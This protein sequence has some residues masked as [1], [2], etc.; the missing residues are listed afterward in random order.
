MKNVRQCGSNVTTSIATTNYIQQAP[1]K[2]DNLI[3]GIYELPNKIHI[4]YN[5][6]TTRIVGR[7]ERFFTSNNGV[8]PFKPQGSER[9]LRCIT[10]TFLIYGRCPAFLMLDVH[11]LLLFPDLFSLLLN[12]YLDLYGEGV[13]KWNIKKWIKLKKV[14]FLKCMSDMTSSVQLLRTL[15]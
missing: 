4:N 1:K 12:T 5:Q 3:K 2:I 15:Y 13:W 8:F 6:T 10:N 7:W 9:R 11:L 14:N